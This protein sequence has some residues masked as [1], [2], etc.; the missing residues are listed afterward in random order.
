MEFMIHTK[1]FIEYIKL[2]RK[3]ASKNEAMGL[4]DDDM[5][6]LNAFPNQL[7]IQTDAQS[8]GI[9]VI[10]DQ[11]QGYEHES[12]GKSRVCAK[13]LFSALKSFPPSEIVH[14]CIRDGMLKLSPASDGYD[15]IKMRR[16]S[17]PLDSH[18]DPVQYSQEISVNREYFIQGLEQV[19]YACS[20]TWYE[21]YRRIRC[22]AKNN[23][24]KFSAGSGGYFAV[25]EYSSDKTALATDEVAFLLPTVNIS[26]IVKLLKKET[27]SHLKIKL[28]QQNLSADVPMQLIIE[29]DHL[30]VRSYDMNKF[31]PDLSKVL[32]HI[33]TYQIPS[34]LQGWENIAEALTAG[35]DSC[36]EIMYLA[37]L[38][39][40]FEAGHIDIQSNSSLKMNRR[41]RF[42]PTSCTFDLAKDKNY[43][44][45]ICC[46]AGYLI[47]MIK[48]NKKKKGVTMYF[49]D[50]STFDSIPKSE[51]HKRAVLFRFAD[52]TDRNEVMEKSAVFFG[53]STKWDDRYL[54]RERESIACPAEIL[55][56]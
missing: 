27:S 34:A 48:K 15:Y 46:C 52:E 38:V 31:Y 51:F 26:T 10:L 14:L 47:D 22:E 56:F 6:Q 11:S 30:I 4:S 8:S 5:I 53:L 36:F 2:V 37:K 28:Q 9:T 25:V 41:V 20:N 32:D 55:D 3:I 1:T 13:E 35:I 44:S 40:D 7:E 12:M 23:T 42:E 54:S 49:E 29:S 33:Y 18:G 17:Y 50:Q 45:W 24:L 16:H 39:I 43:K 21:H 19:H